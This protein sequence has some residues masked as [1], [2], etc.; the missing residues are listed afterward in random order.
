MAGTHTGEEDDVGASVHAHDEGRR[1][2]WGGRFHACDFVGYH[3][4]MFMSL[5]GRSTSYMCELE[6]TWLLNVHADL[7]H[8]HTASKEHHGGMARVSMYV[9]HSSAGM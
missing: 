4:C 7:Q 5:T 9:I 1:R 8:L 2:L 6:L 3:L